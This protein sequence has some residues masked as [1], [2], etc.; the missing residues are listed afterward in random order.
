MLPGQFEIR[1]CRRSG[2][3]FLS[4]QNILSQSEG[5]S[6]SYAIRSPHL[7]LII[8]AARTFVGDGLARLRLSEARTHGSVPLTGCYAARSTAGEPDAAD[9][10]SSANSR[11]GRSRGSHPTKG[12]AD[13]P[14]RASVLRRRLEIP[15]AWIA[16]CFPNLPDATLRSSALS[17]A[18]DRRL[19]RRSV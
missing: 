15:Y 16:P 13:S 17:R 12:V 10:R 14:D 8:I 3:S 11:A 1:G 6:E 2:L 4:L 18:Q 9:F 7:A 19:V 5:S